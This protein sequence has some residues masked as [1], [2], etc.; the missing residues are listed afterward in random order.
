LETDDNSPEP[1]PD[2]D[3]AFFSAFPSTDAD[4]PAEEALA[5]PGAGFA[6]PKPLDGDEAAR[7][8]L[9][10]EDFASARASA[11]AY[12]RTMIGCNN[13]RKVRAHLPEGRDALSTDGGRCG[14]H[15]FATDG[16]RRRSWRL[17]HGNRCKTSA[18]QTG[19]LQ[20]EALPAD[21]ESRRDVSVFGLHFRQFTQS[22][23][24]DM[25]DEL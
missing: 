13:A 20:W 14:G 2:E 10:T 3:G 12:T 22:Q 23:I 4:E 25:R 1:E 17:L 19:R 16:K 24:D 15:R 21:S 9:G 5:S 6:A 8:S 7:A 11:E 18:L